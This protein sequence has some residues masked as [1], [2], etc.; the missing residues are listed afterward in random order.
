[1]GSA[2][3]SERRSQELSSCAIPGI[4]S[5]D[6]DKCY[7]VYAKIKGKKDVVAE[8]FQKALASEYLQQR[9]DACTQVAIMA[10]LV[11]KSGKLP[12]PFFQ[13]MVATNNKFFFRIEAQFN[14][15]RKIQ[16]QGDPYLVKEAVD[17]ILGI[18][19]SIKA[20]SKERAAYFTLLKE[21]GF[22]NTRFTSLDSIQYHPGVAALKMLH[23][24]PMIDTMILGCGRNINYT[25]YCR[26]DQHDKALFVDMSSHIAPDV[27]TDMHNPDFWKKIPSARFQTVLDHTNGHFI[28]DNAETLKQISRVL[29]QGGSFS[30]LHSIQESDTSVMQARKKILEDAGFVVESEDQTVFYKK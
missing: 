28:F 24:D 1:M 27:V 18:N 21:T 4:Y 8:K 25:P 14:C 2:I 13:E 10:F 3:L 17:A 20:S 29:K 6:F 9:Y 19:L 16:A 7:E 5:L 12:T 22:L 26:F 15:F 11:E 30:M 23:Q